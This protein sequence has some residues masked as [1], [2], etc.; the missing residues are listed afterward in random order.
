MPVKS[1][2]IYR[3]LG[4]EGQPRGDWRVELRWGLLAGGTRVSPGE[5]LFPRL[6]PPQE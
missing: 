4:L 5:P 2:E 3:Q 1:A 6:D